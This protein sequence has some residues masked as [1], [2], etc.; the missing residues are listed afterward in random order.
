M[1]SLRLA[2]AQINTHVGDIS[3]NSARIVDW[4]GRAAAAGADLVLFPEMALTGYPVEDLALRKSFVDASRLSLE[5]LA[6][7]LVEHGLG[8][9][10]V[11]VGYLDRAEQDVEA[12][13]DTRG[14]G[15][16]GRPKPQNAAAVLHG[17]RIVSTAAK[18][19]L[20]NYG[21]FDEYR[22]FAPGDVLQVVR[23]RGVDVAVVICEDIWQDGGPVAAAREAGVGLLAVINASPYEKDKDDARDALVGRRAREA[24]CPL[25]YVNLI[26]AQDEL[27]FDGYSVI[28][29]AEGTIVHSA[30]R[31]TESLEVVD[32][33]L[34]AGTAPAGVDPEVGA[35]GM[36]IR[37]TLVTEPGPAPEQPIAPVLQ[38]TLGTDEQVYRALVLGLRDYVT[39]NGLQRVY[40][41]LSGGIDS[42]LVAAIACDAIGADNVY[43]ISNPSAYSSEHSKTDAADLAERTGLHLTTVPIAPIVDAY[44]A[45]M[46]IDGV[47]AENL[48]ARIRA[49]LWLACS[50][51]DGP[52]IVLACGNKSEL[53]VGYSTIYGDAVGGFAPIKDVFKTQVWDLARWRNAQAE[54]A[55]ETP[56]IPENTITKEPSAELRPGQKDTDSLPPYEVLDAI[57]DDYVEGDQGRDHLLAQGFEP[58]LVDRVTRLVDRAEYKRRQYPPGTKIS[59]KAF[60]RD[61]RLPITNGWREGGKDAR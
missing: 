53:A 35:S 1:P 50:N 8:D 44:H 43:G 34:A 46:E 49:N 36:T 55:G 32:L 26:G 25:A 56:P 3:A 31:F 23:V 58:A 20:P 2:M 54:K 18:H 7:R 40:L 39:K 51:A 29:D 41:G 52:S 11:V 24:G 38:D 48:Q 45:S 59:F 19:H 27:V 15:P 5:H 13:A 47:A 37:R 57:L 22:Y 12:V 61:R 21:V 16:D 33:E 6:S 17:G 28:T 42:T 4:A 9:L 14:L 60:G 30:V 10:T